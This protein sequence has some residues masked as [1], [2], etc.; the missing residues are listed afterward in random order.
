MGLTGG[1]IRA[2]GQGPLTPLPAEAGSWR[3]GL[4]ALGLWA[5][6]RPVGP[7]VAGSCR[8]PLPSMVAARSSGV[9]P[10]YRSSIPLVLCNGSSWELW[11]STGRL[12]Q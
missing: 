8:G 2:G 10:S 6:H 9:L 11:S 3:P 12:Q 7:A 4:R 5:P 1:G